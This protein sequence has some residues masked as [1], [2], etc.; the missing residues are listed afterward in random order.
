MKMTYYLKPSNLGKFKRKLI[1]EKR[2]NALSYFLFLII[3]LILFS[4]KE[5]QKEVKVEDKK[6]NIVFVITDDQW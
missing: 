4:C 5:K 1:L 2:N 6:P 3:P